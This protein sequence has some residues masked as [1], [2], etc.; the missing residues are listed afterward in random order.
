MILALVIL[1]SWMVTA[2]RLTPRFYLMLAEGAERE[3]GPTIAND[4]TDKVMRLLAAFCFAL[5]FPVSLLVLYVIG[6]MPKTTAEQQA[7]KAQLD[8]D[9][10]AREAELEHLDNQIAAMQPKRPLRD[11]DA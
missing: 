4:M 2:L 10:R 7:A 6:R 11:L 9:I 1:I 3:Y 5:A 8:H